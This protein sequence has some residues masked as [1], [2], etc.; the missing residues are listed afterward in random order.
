MDFLEQHCIQLEMSMPLTL[1]LSKCW[2]WSTNLGFAFLG[3][4]VYSYIHMHNDQISYY[5]DIE[6][7]IDQTYGHLAD[8]DFDTLLY[9][10]HLQ[11]FCLV[12][13]WMNFF[14]CLWS[15]FSPCLYRGLWM[16]ALQ[17]HFPLTLRSTKCWCCLTGFVFSFL[18]H[19]A[20][21]CIHMYNDQTSCSYQT[22]DLLA[23]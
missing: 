5:N 15:C 18:G 11:D 12:L 10:R 21:S 20:S 14:L 23:N 3:H 13:L 19:T 22:C 16:I 6:F 1:H 17:M 4:I 2:C 7:F 8:L 9:H